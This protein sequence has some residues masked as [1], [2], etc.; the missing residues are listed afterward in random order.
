VSGLAARTGTFDASPVDYDRDGDGDLDVHG[1]VPGGAQG[2]DPH[3][4]VHRNAD[5]RFSGVRVPAAGGP[6]DAVAA[7]RGNRD[8]HAEVL[9]RN[10]LGS[11][12]ALQRIE[13]VHR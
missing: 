11:P 4:L 9:V 1:L 12:G 13:L 10:G 7:L 5:L 2:T 8:A 3:A 6:G